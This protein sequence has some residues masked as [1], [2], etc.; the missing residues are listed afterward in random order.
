MIVTSVVKPSPELPLLKEW[1]VWDTDIPPGRSELHVPCVSP[2]VSFF[3]N[4]LNE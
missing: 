3:E 1:D 2:C 4:L